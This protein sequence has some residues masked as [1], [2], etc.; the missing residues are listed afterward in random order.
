MSDKPQSSPKFKRPSPAL[1]TLVTYQPMPYVRGWDEAKRQWLPIQDIKF[2]SVK[3]H[4]WPKISAPRPTPATMP[5]LEDVDGTVKG[6]AA[7]LNINLEFMFDGRDD[8]GIPSG[9]AY[10]GFVE[11]DYNCENPWHD[12]K[13]LYDSIADDFPGHTF[14]IVVNSRAD[15]LAGVKMLMDDFGFGQSPQEYL[16][17]L[18]FRMA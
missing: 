7:L 13:A 18:K 15:Y 12:C 11:G 3:H 2:D 16:D 5:S 10:A 17:G 8:Q 4:T 14:A 9:P 1:A 6:K